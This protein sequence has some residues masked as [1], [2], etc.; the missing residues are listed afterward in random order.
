VEVQKGVGPQQSVFVLQVCPAPAQPH[1]PVPALH[2][3][4]QQSADALQGVASAMQPHLPVEVQKGVGPQQSV[5]V[6]Q[7]CPAPAQPQVEV[8]ELQSLV[9][10]SLPVLQGPVSATHGP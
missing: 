8:A 2:T 3:A 5:F 9:Q 10:Q 1:A 4:V 6:L 7:V